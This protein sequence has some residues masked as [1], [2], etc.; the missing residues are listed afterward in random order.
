MDY[1]MGLA[2]EGEP[3]CGAEVRFAPSTLPQCDK[4]AHREGE[5]KWVLRAEAPAWWQKTLRLRKHRPAAEPNVHVAIVWETAPAPLLDDSRRSACFAFLEDLPSV[6]TCRR[7]A[8]HPL[9]SLDR[10][11]HAREGFAAVWNEP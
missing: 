9:G 1:L 3:V 7:P 5:H 10:H 2:K 4:A 11:K 8:G 6:V